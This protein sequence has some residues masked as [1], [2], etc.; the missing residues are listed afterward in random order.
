M[1]PEW[2]SAIATAIATVVS[3]AALCHSIMTGR[4]VKNLEKK[5]QSIGGAA[6]ANTGNGVVNIIGQTTGGGARMNILKN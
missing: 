2:I 5:Y 1:T 3:L 6:V 4:K